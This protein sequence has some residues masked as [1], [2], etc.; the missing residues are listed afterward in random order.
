[1]RV[2]LLVAVAVAAL[3]AS[4]CTSQR[5]PEPAPLPTESASPSATS[6]PS[7]SAPTL[8][9]AAEGTSPAA[10]KAFARH[11]FATVNYAA[12][13]GDTQELRSLGL[14][15]CASCDAIASNIEKVYGEGGY[16]AE[17]DWQVRSVRVVQSTETRAFLSITAFLTPEV[18]VDAE[19]K[20]TTREGGKQPMSMTL[21]RRNGRVHVATLDLV[22]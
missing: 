4:G 9:P 6:S 2:R 13:T 16:I 18:T 12:A 21:A 19:G 10:A 1:M 11:Y 17:E 22:T 14:R 5:A 8:P 3:L 15:R 20:R 7:P